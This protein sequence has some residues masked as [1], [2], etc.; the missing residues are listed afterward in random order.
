MELLDLKNNRH[1][2]VK[3]KKYAQVEKVK[4]R[5]NKWWIWLLIGIAIGYFFP[6]VLKLTKKTL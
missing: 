2:K 6:K 3:I 4:A 5:R 1:E